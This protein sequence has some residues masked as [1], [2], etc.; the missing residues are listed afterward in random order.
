MR[1][2][3]RIQSLN[4]VTPGVVYLYDGDKGEIVKLRFVEYFTEATWLVFRIKML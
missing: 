2:N 4:T 3:Y 1:I